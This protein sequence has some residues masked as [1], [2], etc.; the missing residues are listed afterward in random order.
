MTLVATYSKRALGS[1][2]T[3]DCFVRVLESI[4]SK[5]QLWIL[6]DQQFHLVFTWKSFH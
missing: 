4:A 3:N 2:S 6:I 1:S 5:V